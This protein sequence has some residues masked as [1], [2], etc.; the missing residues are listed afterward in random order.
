MAIAATGFFLIFIS[1]SC[2]QLSG[3][4]IRL[5]PSLMDRNE[6]D[7][8]RRKFTINLSSDVQNSGDPI[9]DEIGRRF[10]RAL[11]N[12]LSKIKS[13]PVSIQLPSWCFYYSQENPAIAVIQ[14]YPLQ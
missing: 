10:R 11:S 12:D 8:N 1:S 4:S 14:E 9:M 2:L 6:V 13:T 3:A 5:S 7:G